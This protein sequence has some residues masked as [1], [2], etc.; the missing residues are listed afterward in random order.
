MNH[1]TNKPA[2]SQC[3]PAPD[4]MPQKAVQAYPGRRVMCTLQK[5]LPLGRE[6]EA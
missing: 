2:I 3:N 5:G 4:N 6:G 1:E